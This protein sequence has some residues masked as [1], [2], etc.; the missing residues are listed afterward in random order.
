MYAIRSYYVQEKEKDFL[1]K[2]EL[3][4]QAEKKRLF[5]NLLLLQF[6]IL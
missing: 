5:L 4:A 1:Y 6:Q 2:K 3:L